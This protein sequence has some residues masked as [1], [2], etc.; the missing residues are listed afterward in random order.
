MKIYLEKQ[1]LTKYCVTKYL[2]L[3]KIRNVVEIKEVLLHWF[4]NILKKSTSTAD[5]SAVGVRW[6]C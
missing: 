5:K 3:L 6:S 2:I 4:T 1:H